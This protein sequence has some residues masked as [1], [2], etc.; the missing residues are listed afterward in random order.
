MLRLLLLSLLLLATSQAQQ[1][2]LANVAYGP[3]PLQVLDFYQAQAAQ[4]TAL[5]FFIHGGGWTSGDKAKP[6]FLTQCQQ[7]GIS[8]VSIN[9]RLLADAAAAQI[10]PPVKACLD[11]AARALQFVRS[12]ATE[13]KFDKKRIG[14][15]GGSAGG[16]TILYL[17]FH[18]DMAE[19]ESPDPIARESTRLSCALGFVPQTTLDPQLL[20]A[21]I[22][23]SEYGPH[24]FGLS[25]MQ[26]L[27]TQR[28]QHL[29]WIER[30]SPYSLASKDDPPVLLFYDN[31]PQLGQPY[32]DPPHS[33]NFGAGIGSRLK[34]L[35]LEHELNYNN[36]YAHMR[37]PDLFGFFLEKLKQ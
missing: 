34:E 23:N 6:D 7:H 15:C 27:L 14:G 31:A 3:H 24:A 20:R 32:K 19:P 12:K 36:D 29:P 1:P 21:W 4:P 22:P 33:A 10:Q 9:Y 8:L 25:S 13:W 30:Y 5:L 28:A 37:Y 2:T 11:D 16:C 35:G 17:A 18:D 26:E